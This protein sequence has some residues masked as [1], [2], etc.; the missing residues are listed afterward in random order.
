MQAAECRMLDIAGSSQA[1]CLLQI[2]VT[3]CHDL[4]APALPVRAHCRSQMVAAV[5]CP[6]ASFPA[7]LSSV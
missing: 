5:R 1:V 6:I 3:P 7:M 2:H 4:I